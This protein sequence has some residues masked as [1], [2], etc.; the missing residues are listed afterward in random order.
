MRRAAWYLALLCLLN[1]LSLPCWANEPIKLGILAFRPQAIA[2][3]Q[4]QPL[5]AALHKAI[6]DYDFVIEAYDFQALHA[7]VAARQVDFVLTNPSSYLV[8]A[9]HNGLSAPLL[10]L[11]NIEQGKA[12]SAMGGVIFS[13]A[14]RK[15]LQQLKDLKNKT[16]AA[17]APDS[18]G[19]YQ[20]QAY[21][22]NNISLQISKN[23][24]VLFTGMPQDRVITE[25]LAGRADVGFVRSGELESLAYE[26][27]LD[28][29]QIKI[30]H[31]ENLPDFPVAVST[32]LY[33]EWPLS[34]MP[35]MNKELKRRV[36]AYLLTLHDDTKLTRALSI[37]GFD[38]PADYSSVETLLRELRMPP[39]DITPAFTSNDVWQRYRSAILAI[40]LALSAIVLLGF[41]LIRVNRRLQVEK[42][43]VQLHTEQL[44]ANHALLDNIIEN[45]PVMVTLKRATDLSYTLINRAGEALLGHERSELIGRNH[46]EVEFKE[47]ADTATRHERDALRHHGVMDIPNELVYTPNGPRTLHT[48]QIVLRD[49]HDVPLYL[50]GISEDITE[51]LAANQALLELN[52]NLAATLQAIPDLMF[53]IDE[54]GTYLNIWAQNAELLYAQK[55]RLLGHTVNEMLPT[56]AAQTVMAALEEAKRIGTSHGR[57]MQLKLP[58]GFGWFELSV[59]LKSTSDMGPCHF[60]AMSRDITQRILAEQTLRQNE[61]RLR[62][63]LNAAKQ[64]WYDVNVQTGE[65]LVSPEYIKMLGHDPQSFHTDLDAWIASL[66]P[67]DT[68]ELLRVLRESLATGEPR[69]M[70]YRRRNVHGE[71]IWISSVGQVTEWDAQ[72][73]PLR[74]VG[75]HTDIS[76]RKSAEAALL[77]ANRSLA[78]LSA[79]NRN[80]V[81]VN[82]ERQLLHSVCQTIVDQSGYRMAWVGYLQHDEAHSIRPMAQVGF[83]QGYL[84]AAHIVWA[85]VEH[86]RGTTGRAARTGEVQI[87]QDLLHDESMKLWREESRQRGYRSCLSLPLA[88]QG[89]VF[90]VL[91]IYADQTD[92]FSDTDIDL[93]TE[94][95]NDLAFGVKSLQARHERDIALEALSV[96][97]LQLERANEQ[98][99]D[100][101]AM[102]AK[103]VEERTAQLSLANKAKDAFLATMSHEIRTP[104]GGLLGMMELLHLS[105]MDSK[106]QKMLEVARYSGKSLLRIVDDILD[107]SKIEAGKLAIIASPASLHETL[108]LIRE[109]YSE[110]A[111]AKGIKLQVHIDP[112]LN[113]VHRFD[114]IR[115]AQIMHNFTSNALKFTQLG[116][117]ELSATQVS[118]E[119]DSEVV[120]LCVKDTGIGISATQIQR[121]FEHYEQASEDTA[122][123][124]G[125]TGLGLAICRSLAALMGGELSVESKIGHGSTFCLTI[126]LPIAADTAITPSLPTSNFGEDTHQQFGKL[127][128]DDHAVRILL[129][130]DQPVN[131]MLLK[132]LL[133]IFEVEVDAAADG[134]EALALWQDGEYDLIIT[135]CHMPEMDGYEFTRNVRN[136]EQAEG[137]RHTPIIAW[138][139]NVLSDEWGRSMGAGMDD[140]LTKPTELHTLQAMLLKWL[141]F[142]I[143]TEQ[144]ATPTVISLTNDE[145]A[146][147]DFSVLKKFARNHDAQI[148]LL[149][150]FVTH[151]REDLNDLELALQGT[152]CELVARSAHRIKG[153][154]RMVGAHILQ[155]LCAS[156][157][158][159]AQQG[160]LN[161]ARAHAQQH[162]SGIVRDTESAIAHYLASSQS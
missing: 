66:H 123:M 116:S 59:S 76:E 88:Q 23:M 149:K 143:T 64:G 32:Q 41:N 33:P 11:S 154:A 107:W 67:D 150:A 137:T 142:A 131:R 144:L 124:Y 93:L 60:I 2:Q 114:P 138:T 134:A 75:V 7:V 25:V 73:Q 151:N 1:L 136:I 13:K 27:K 119:Q 113:T 77:H 45:I 53:E 69:T 106:Q 58:T 108:H 140:M 5:A 40:A 36:A 72:H 115:V 125:G 56:A 43:L 97:A 84:E 39:Y 26:G 50:L 132:H 89:Q 52:S 98:V 101:R 157:E 160:E 82:D 18:L 118:R 112:R 51:R 12:V 6:P 155:R 122:R 61:E 146:L 129:V 42:R 30:I 29:R 162:L 47:Q 128:L 156:I 83:E 110:A 103:R 96:T 141:P 44:T 158:L 102:L 91:V 95:S 104:L 78:I 48:K 111:A 99:E 15:D 10:T 86:G 130:D 92:A 139:A 16:I 79:V 19:G 126:A 133:E 49:E 90:G 148:E 100:E 35:Q 70:Q 21:E 34:A 87:S 120:R 105:H 9:K 145:L 8:L 117:I 85:D 161:Q 57:V 63:A 54:Y 14:D 37:N 147:I 22:L 74:M 152:E 153:A 109:S 3:A 62:L 121:L 4:W 81:H 94:M 68:E 80:L 71:W 127:I 24:R 38:V 159:A 55:E 28:M 135:D 46:Y 17:T 31:R 65:I 20:M